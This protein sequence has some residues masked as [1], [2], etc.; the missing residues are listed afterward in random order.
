MSTL[1]FS[2]AG[3]A[4]G[5]LAVHAAKQQYPEATVY[6]YQA[7]TLN[8]EEIKKRIE[9]FNKPNDKPNDKSTDEKKHV[10][11]NE[12]IVLDLVVN[13]IKPIEN[14]KILV[15]DHHEW[16]SKPN[17]RDTK[18]N[19]RETKP[20]DR[21]TKPNDDKNFVFMHD[22]NFSAAVLAWKYF[23][24]TDL[25]RL[26]EYVQDRDLFAK[27]LKNT[28]EIMSIYYLYCYKKTTSELLEMFNESK[29]I[30][31]GKVLME[32][33][34]QAIE[35]MVKKG[36]PFRFKK[37]VIPEQYKVLIMHGDST[38]K[39]D[40]GNEAVKQ[41]YDIGIYFEWPIRPNEIWLSFRSKD[42]VD[43]NELCRHITNKKGMG[44]GHKKASGAT[45]DETSHCYATPVNPANWIETLFEP[46]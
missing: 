1:I 20:N 39:S 15:I 19:D 31:Q 26:Y 4:D 38:L 23:M 33:R 27:K 32:Q 18:P 5:S 2:H 3:C 29:W 14:V 16:S 22:K 9:T 44:G 28:P 11:V 40:A 36:V 25:P 41:G 42:N 43:V 37:N 30:E 13:D 35:Y 45:I 24:K 7:G 12:I 17:D 10:T 34:N 8:M 6:Y 21:E 46:I